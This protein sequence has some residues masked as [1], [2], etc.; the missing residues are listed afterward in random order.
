MK[1]ICALRAQF[2]GNCV[3]GSLDCPASSDH[4]PMAT[5][6]G[7][8]DGNGAGG[9]VT[10]TNHI[11]LGYAVTGGTITTAGGGTRAGG[12]GGGRGKKCHGC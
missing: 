12:G 4:S 7:G 10:I 8:A 1:T 2:D 6:T 11:A 3:F 9:E 5:G